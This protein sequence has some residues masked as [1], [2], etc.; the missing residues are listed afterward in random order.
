MNDF[1]DVYIKGGHKNPLK[2]TRIRYTHPS[3]GVNEYVRLYANSASGLVFRDD[4]LVRLWVMEA[5]K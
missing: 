4:Y 1:I 5:S 2:M 3:L